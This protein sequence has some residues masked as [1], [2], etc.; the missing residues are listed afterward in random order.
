[1]K[2]M[3]KSNTCI[4]VVAMALAA[5]AVWFVKMPCWGKLY[6]PEM[7]EQLKD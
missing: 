5:V 6:E 1:M 2:L 4:Q 7:P 3:E